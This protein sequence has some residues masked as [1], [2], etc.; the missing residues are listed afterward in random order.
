MG[1]LGRYLCTAAALILTVHALDAD[2]FARSCRVCGE[3]VPEIDPGSA[4]AAL[5]LLAGGGL[6]FRARRSS[7]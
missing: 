6:L 3:V 1:R 2:A 5:A 7:K 4:S